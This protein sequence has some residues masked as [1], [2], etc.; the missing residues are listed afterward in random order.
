MEPVL[1]GHDMRF[2]L[3]ILLVL[4]FFST[5]ALSDGNYTDD[6][7]EVEAKVILDGDTVSINIRMYGIDSPESDQLCERSDG[8]CWKCGERAQEVLS[9]LI[10]GRKASFLFT[11]DVTWGRPVA[12]I[13]V[14]ALDINKE[15]I[16][17]GYA[18]V[19]SRFLTAGVKSDYFAAQDEA[20]SAKRGV[21]Q[22]NFVMPWDWRNGDRLSCE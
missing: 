8:S 9:G 19:F 18:V 1:W 5:G 22:G 4:S 2:S 13:K 15:L 7:D 14:R 12:T 6:L 16:R 11:G 3:V 17:Q 10:K 20:K 21:W